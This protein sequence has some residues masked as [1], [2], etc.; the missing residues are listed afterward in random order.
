M[1]L[2]LSN[3]Q[4]ARELDLG[5]ADVQAMAEQLRCGLVA[6]LPPARLEGE[7]EIDEVYVVAGHKGN[8]TAVAK[9]GAPADAGG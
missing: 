4:I 6:K 7:V 3:R 1:G 9:G 5:E 8:P 2:N